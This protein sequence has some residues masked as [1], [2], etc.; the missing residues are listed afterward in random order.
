MV[1]DNQGDT[2][3]EVHKKMFCKADI[4]DTVHDDRVKISGKSFQGIGGGIEG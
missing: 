4:P 2:F 1:M 3:P